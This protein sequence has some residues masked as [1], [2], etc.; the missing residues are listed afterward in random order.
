MKKVIMF[1]SG[2]VL[3]LLT[4]VALYFSGA[5][6]DT[7]N[8]LGINTFIFQPNNLSENRI[9]HPVPIDKLSDKFIRERLI[10]KFVMEYFYITPDTENIAQRIR[11]D[12][13]LAA[14]SAPAVFKEW[15][16]GMAT[17]I[18]KLAGEKVLR[19]V[20][21]ADEIIRPERGDYW[22]VF[23]ELRTW[24]T[25]NDMASVPTVEHGVIY[26]KISFEKGVHDQ[27][28]GKPFD[29]QKYLQEGGDPAAIFKFRVDEV[30]QAGS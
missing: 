11:N 21:I 2:L 1:F 8:N 18:E 19:T 12:S 4:F 28:G 15:R 26:L 20:E 27:R 23:Y 13:I 3:L 9:G 7:G 22:E 30:A 29:V 6:F 25:P 16:Q 24:D 10:K 17:D 5:L 14:M